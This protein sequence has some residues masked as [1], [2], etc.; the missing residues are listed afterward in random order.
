MH[1]RTFFT[2]ITGDKRRW[3]AWGGVG[4]FFVLALTTG[5]FLAQGDISFKSLLAGLLSTSE[6]T[7]PCSITAAST[8]THERTLTIQAYCPSAKFFKI[9]ESPDFKESTTTGPSVTV[10]NTDPNGEFVDVAIAYPN[11]STIGGSTTP[12][13]VSTERS[14]PRIM[15][16][17]FD[18]GGDIPMP[19]YATPA[20]AEKLIFG[21]NFDGRNMFNS[22]KAYAEQNTYGAVT[23]E[24]SVIP[25][26]IHLDLAT[27]RD[28]SG[29]LNQDRIAKA[30]AD[31]LVAKGYVNTNTNPYSQL[32]GLTPGGIILNSANTYHM[33]SRTWNYNGFPGVLLS[34]IPV[35]SDSPVY[36]PVVNE[37]QIVTADGVVVPKY[38]TSNVSGVWLRSDPEHTGPNYFQKATM[39]YLDTTH[40]FTNYFL[41]YL[42]L[43]QPLTPGTEVLV[44]YTP[45]VGYK[46]NPALTALTPSDTLL[47][48]V[49]WYQLLSH[50]WIHSAASLLIR[51]PQQTYMPLL[52]VYQTPWENTRDYDMMASGNQNYIRIFNGQLQDDIRYSIPSS[53]T[54]HTKMQIGVFK[55]YTL[56]YGQNVQNLRI[57]QTT[58]SDYANTDNRIKL[59]KIPLHP[60]GEKGRV[61][62]AYGTVV[63][64]Y[65]G[66]DY[67]TLEVRNK[68]TFANGKENFDSAL[69][70]KGLLIYRHVEGVSNVTQEQPSMH[71]NDQYNMIEL[72][73]ATPPLP[74]FASLTDYGSK[75]TLSIGNSAAT[76]GGESGVYQYIANEPWNWKDVDTATVDFDLSLGFGTK[77][78]YAKFMDLNGL[79]TSVEPI[80]VTFNAPTNDAVAPTAAI[81]SPSDGAS[82]GGQ[83]SVNVTAT[84]NIAVERVELTVDNTALCTTMSAP[85]SCV[86][87]T[88]SF[89]NGLHT[90]QARALD[91]SGN[92]GVSNAISVTVN[93]V[94]PDTMP[95]TSPTNLAISGL[96]SSTVTLSWLASSDNISVMG[97]DVY[98]I[99][100]AQEPQVV[101]TVTGTTFN[102]T[103][104]TPNTVYSYFVRARDTAGNVSADSNI[105]TATTQ[106]QPTTGVISGKVTNATGSVLNGVKI[107]AAKGK[108]KKSTSTNNLGEYSLL[109][110]APGVYNVTYSLRGYSTK[111]VAVSVVAGDT[112]T[113][114]I[115]LSR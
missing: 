15:V 46:I 102:D 25:E 40:T 53:L 51:Q 6:N 87:D 13:S 113:Q 4:T 9:S 37:A 7:N 45:S 83:I 12:F 29:T 32:I 2:T 60:S 20:W 27:Y 92:I 24:G 80:T 105:V 72:Q 98:R 109:S 61:Q 33:F 39:D 26:V 100:S 52:D 103:G 64:T 3:I 16:V 78:L 10:L 50:E 65:T 112:I 41:T 88:G 49:R 96:T 30:L 81:L 94:T 59:V 68:N 71:G 44:S 110:L 106:A 43:N 108:I 111:T 67:L 77:T 35:T 95:P 70:H 18:F 34:D 57:W 79:V 73:D 11:G 42:I 14:T 114:N 55:P 63:R 91:A 28:L 104:L 66:E 36:N 74:P 69:P 19:A 48:G 82:V 31:I 97:Y 99:N 47:D 93:N 101:G 107:V 90:L 76:F 38:N 56:A 86:W 21:R 17:L 62:M 58:E 89:I 8:T 54:G 22:L 84:D 1:I 23:P 75:R 115:T 5:G 85:Y